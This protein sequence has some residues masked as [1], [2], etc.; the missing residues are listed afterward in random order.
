MQIPLLRPPP[1]DPLPVDTGHYVAAL[2]SHAGERDAL[3]HTAPDIWERMTPLIQLVGPKGRSEPFKVQT[4]RGWATR[5][6]Q[7]LASHPLYLDVTRLN[8]TF[9]VTTP[10]GNMPVLECI[11]EASRLRGLRFVPVTWVGESTADHRRIVGDAALRDGHGVALRYRMRKYLPPMG[12]GLGAYVEGE[13][14]ALG[15]DASDADLIVDLEYLDPDDE[16]DPDGM[17]SSLSE[18]VAVGSWRSVVILG[19]SIPSVLSSIPEGAVGSLVRKEWELWSRLQQ[20]DLERMPAFG[21][22]AIQNP[23]PPHEGGGPGMRANIRYTANGETLIARGRGPFYE[24]G[25][26]Q[27]RGLCEQLVGRAEFAGR[28]FSWGDAVIDD[29]ARGAVEPGGQRVWRGAG[30]SHHLQTVTQQLAAQT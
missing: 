6:S 5:I 30:T 20:F 10:E 1:L 12:T 11:Y 9:P 4:V 26:E 15:T 25:N 22:Y 16:I 2:Q 17:A 28:G 8:P 23:H 14:T 27:Y 3:E 21:D 18:M 24:E 19:T 13:L 7:S 29:C